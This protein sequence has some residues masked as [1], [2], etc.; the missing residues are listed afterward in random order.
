MPKL[1]QHMLVWLR[2]DWYELRSQDGLSNHLL[3]NDHAWWLAWL[4]EHIS[5]AFQGRQGH[6]TL[7]KERRARGGDYWYAYRSLNRQTS[8]KYAGRTTDLSVEHLEEIASWFA[9]KPAIPEP[10]AVIP[11][12]SSS[13]TTI[14]QEQGKPLLEPKF[15][16][17]RLSAALVQRARLLSRV[18]AGLESKLLLFCAP[19]G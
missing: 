18:N 19:A 14:L 8:K 2:D 9:N 16:M 3:Q 7:L 6:L 1:A 5:F 15:H 11:Q 12:Q 4:T 13:P 17:P 10:E